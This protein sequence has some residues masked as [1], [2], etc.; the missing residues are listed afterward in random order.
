MDQQAA[1]IELQPTESGRKA[2]D[3][4]P[5]P[6]YVIQAILPSLPPAKRVLDPAC[7]VGEILLEMQADQRLGIELDPHRAELAQAAGVE[8]VA[9]NALDVAWPDAELMAFNPPFVEALAFAEL[10]LAW[11]ERDPRRTI[12]MLARITFLESKERLPLHRAN[13]SDVFIFGSRPKFRSDRKGTDSATVAWFVWGPGR[14]G[15]WSVL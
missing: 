3:Y 13:P 2:L 8:V 10:A 1:P 15:R 11:R 9:G 4:Y 7:G 14:G 6:K 12:A 5:T